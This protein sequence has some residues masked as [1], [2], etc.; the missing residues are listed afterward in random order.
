MKVLYDDQIFSAQKIG[1][2]S[3]YFYELIKRNENAII[4]LIYTENFYFKKN[5]ITL[6]FGK[7]I[8]RY[9]NKIN[10]FKVKQFLIKNNFDIFHPTYYDNYFL[11]YLKNK[12]IE[13]YNLEKKEYIEKILELQKKIREKHNLRTFEECFKKN[14]E[15]IIKNENEIINK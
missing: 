4:P 9:L 15:I 3:R 10:R 14:I 6:K 1:G 8:K 7:K 2:I 13:I 11:K 5:K 12:I